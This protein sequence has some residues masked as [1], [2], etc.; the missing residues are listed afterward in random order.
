L[1]DFFLWFIT[2]LEHIADWKGYD[3]IL[4]I[5]ALCAVYK[6]KKELFFI[7]TSFTIGHSVTLTLSVINFISI[8]TNIIE[9]LIPMTILGTCIFNFF[10]LEVRKKNNSIVK[11]GFAL[12]FGFIHGMG[13]STLL[14]SML[15]SEENFTLPLFAFNLGLEAGQ[16]V[17]I[18]VF[19]SLI[20]LAGLFLKINKRDKKLFLTSTTFGIALIMAIE[21]FLELL[22]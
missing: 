8:S 1:S 13:F 22:N 12:F 17:I 21:R 16:I 2:G 3:H 5:V 4:F 7:V 15:G 18:A 9:F 10:N 14:K 11:Y 19:L 20:F 6:S